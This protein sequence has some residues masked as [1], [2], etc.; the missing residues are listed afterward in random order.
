VHGLR[1]NKNASEAQNQA[2]HHSLSANQH[3]EGE[4]RWV[5]AVAMSDA[6]RL[7]LLDCSLSEA[8][9]EIVAC[10]G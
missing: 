8:V 4:A 6:A 1:R 5:R 10:Y 9:D 2:R 3:W 7:A